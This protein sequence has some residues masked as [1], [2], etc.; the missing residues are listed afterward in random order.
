M[1]VDDNTDELLTT[2]Q[3]LY[4]LSVS[5]Y[6]EEHDNTIDDGKNFAIRLLQSSNRRDEATELLTKLLATSKQVLGPHHK[7]TKGIE[8]T[9]KLVVAEREI[10]NGG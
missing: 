7:T 3:E 10:V 8:A 5:K 9:L 4:E 1:L 6:G 2:Y